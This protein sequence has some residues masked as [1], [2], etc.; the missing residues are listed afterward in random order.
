M[1]MLKL[2]LS[3]SNCNYFEAGGPVDP[4]GKKTFKYALDVVDLHSLW[5][6]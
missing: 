6:D 1:A 2:G 5:H 4:R 3:D